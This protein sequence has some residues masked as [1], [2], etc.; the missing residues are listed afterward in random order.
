MTAQ[1]PQLLVSGLALAAVLLLI[2]LFSWLARRIPALAMP[3]MRLKVGSGAALTLRGALA[4]D[5]RRRLYL[6]EVEGRHAL[7]LTG[8]ATEAIVCLPPPAA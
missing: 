1:T 5:T 8:G 7:V 6:V 3:T 2:L 4:L